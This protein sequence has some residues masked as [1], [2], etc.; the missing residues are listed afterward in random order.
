VPVDKW[1]WCIFFQPN[2]G[3]VDRQWASTTQH[4]RDKHRDP[5]EIQLQR[6]DL[7]KARNRE[8]AKHDR[9]QAPATPRIKKPN[10]RGEGN[11]CHELR[12]R[13][14]KG[15]CGHAHDH[16]PVFDLGLLPAADPYR[17]SAWT[18]LRRNER[19]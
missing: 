16:L 11:C 6:W 5:E 2:D 3:A 4:V 8:R 14:W 12:N 13:D 9:N 10:D 1:N 17:T 18:P 19:A 7:H 15:D